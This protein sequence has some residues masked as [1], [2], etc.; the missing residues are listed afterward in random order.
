MEQSSEQQPSERIDFDR[1]P[2]VA[3]SDY[4]RMARIVLPGYEAMHQMAL[5]VLKSRLASTANL[6]VVAAG[7]G[8]ELIRY[9]MSNPQ[10]RLLGV[11]PSADM[12]AIAQT[13]INEHQLS[14]QIELYRGYTQ[15]LP[16]NPLYD[17]ATAI[18]VMHF[19]PDDGSKL[20]FLQA[21][22]HRLQPSA[23]FILVDVFGEKHTSEFKQ[24]ICFIRS[25]WQEMGLPSEQANELIEKMN[26]SVYP[27]S[28]T[29]LIDLFADAGFERP[30]RFY[31]GLWVGGW[32]TKKRV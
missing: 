25:H 9:G 31:T 5:S 13:K 3:T 4:D 11:D 26:T 2:T 10:W 18:L 12:L 22:S 24:T 32:V 1:N 23:S 29:R 7:T 16:I 8:M 28:E 21:I 27:I 20:E 30:I 6:L 19:I 17:A 15:D 14:S